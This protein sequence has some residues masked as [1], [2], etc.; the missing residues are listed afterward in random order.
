[1]IVDTSEYSS[2]NDISFQ[3]K[4][5]SNSLSDD[6]I[7]Y[8]PKQISDYRKS[9]SYSKQ[10]DNSNHPLY[11][12]QLCKRYVKYGFCLYADTCAFAHGSHELKS[13]STYKTKC[14]NYQNSGQ[15]K[16]GDKCQFIHEDRELYKSRYSRSPHRDSPYSRTIRKRQDFSF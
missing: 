11:K 13:L 6:D 12:T 4:I 1:M 16:Y 9:S 2:E 3:A 8:S 15:C 7:S 10:V 14:T 5:V